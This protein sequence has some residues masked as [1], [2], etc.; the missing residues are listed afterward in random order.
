MNSPEKVIFSI[1]VFAIIPRLNEQTYKLFRKIFDD[2]NESKVE[3]SAKIVSFFLLI[4]QLHGW[5]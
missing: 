3:I 5:A 4:Q 1:C 2:Q